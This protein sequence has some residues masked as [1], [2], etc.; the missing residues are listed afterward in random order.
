VGVGKGI[1]LITYGL[2]YIA[3]P[4][5]GWRTP[6][7]R[8]AGLAFSGVVET[9]GAEVD[10]FAVGD[11]VFGSHAGALA[12][13][14]V[15]PEGAI[16]RK[17]DS[18]DFEQ[19]AA[20]PI[21]GLA[22][23]QAV[24]AGKVEPGHHVLVIG[25]SGGVGSFAVQVAK[26][27][28]ATVTGVAS[29][30]NLDLL[31]RLGADHVIDYTREE[32]PEKP[33]Y[34]VIIDI[35]GNRPVTRLRRALVAAGTLVIA[36]GTGSRLTMGFERTIGGMLLSPFVRQRI[37]GLISTPNQRDLEALAEL[38]ASGKVVPVVQRRFRFEQAADA[39]ELAGSGRGSG[40]PVVDV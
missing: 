13:C 17:P 9:V 22:A 23:L 21:S 28:G 15:V 32:I 40:T 29:T 33:V 16:A 24:R 14:I 5:Y 38:M 7:E 27:S 10:R 30:R 31:R 37:V 39:I 4:S 19:A 6:K 11:E 36:G 8:V 20:A 26:A 12:E 25:A 34:D 18:V 35:A 2:P 1:W 3:R